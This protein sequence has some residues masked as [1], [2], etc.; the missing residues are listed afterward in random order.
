MRPA[1]RRP[2]RRPC[3]AA[4]EGAP[5]R[6]TPSPFNSVRRRQLAA[7]LR[8]RVAHIVHLNNLMAHITRLL[9]DGSDGTISFASAVR[10]TLLARPAK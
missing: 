5:G 6:S 3:A 1:A 7:F 4:G 8:N 10:T 9:Q 2:S